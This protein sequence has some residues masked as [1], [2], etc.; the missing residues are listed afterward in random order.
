MIDVLVE[1]STAE[2]EGFIRKNIGKC[3]LIV[4]NCCVEYRGRASSKLGPGE[5]IIII[6]EDG[7]LLIHHQ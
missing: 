2:A 7:A 4:G 6:K 5:R 1:P 3:L